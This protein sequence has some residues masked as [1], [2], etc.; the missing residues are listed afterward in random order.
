MRALSVAQ[1]HPKI[2]SNSC[3]PGISNLA[4]ASLAFANLAFA[5]LAFA[6][7]AFANLGFANLALQI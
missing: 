7:L 6:N 1:A 5:N 3:F 2:P 4:F